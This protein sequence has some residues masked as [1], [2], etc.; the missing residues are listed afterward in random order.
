MRLTVIGSGSAFSGAGHNAC[1]CVDGRL[2]VDC[3]SPAQYLLAEAGR[4]VDD[5]DG[6]LLTHFHADHTA[7]IPVVLGAR[8]LV[9]D[10]PRP[11]GL[12]GPPG[13]AE[14]VSRL[15]ST[16]YGSHLHKLIYD[17]LGLAFTM[18]QDGSDTEFCGY[19]IRAHS[20]VHSTG[21][22]LAYAISDPSGASVGFSGD[23]TL[24]A[25]LRRA[26][27]QSQLMVCECSGFDR[28]IPTHLWFGE[29]SELMDAHPGTRFVLSHLTDRRPVRGAILAHDLLSVDVQAPGTPPPDPPASV[30]AAR[31]AR[32][33]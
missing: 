2:L 14:Y 33:S 8:A 31:T 29:I 17:R 1:Y 15:I 16:G 13:T 27:S 9:H 26:V 19:R 20:V 30:V 4:S 7:M 24:C 12:A 10:T 25:G 5:L 28:P 18:L 21:P 23:S 6:L 22:S 11:M 3:G 32:Q